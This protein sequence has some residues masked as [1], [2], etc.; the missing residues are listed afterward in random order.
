VKVTINIDGAEQADRDSLNLVFLAFKAQGLVSIKKLGA[1]LQEWS[2]TC[3]GITH[4]LLVS[5]NY[6]NTINS[7]HT[8]NSEHNT[9]PET[10]SQEGSRLKSAPVPAGQ[11]AQE[12]IVNDTKPKYVTPPKPLELF[13]QRLVP[14][15]EVQDFINHWNER[16]WLPKIRATDRQCK[17]IRI[18]L[19]RPVFADM[20]KQGVAEV[21]KSKFLRGAVPGYNGHKFKMTIDWFLHPDNFDKIMEGK[22]RDE[23]PEIP[24]NKERHY[25]KENL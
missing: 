11:S 2:F 21:A 23:E 25:D 6:V 24:P 3:A 9:N 16:V 20:Y 19:S 1:S 8:T 14:R 18:A 7:N 13:A 10:H 4:T 5:I 12:T 17:E 15:H 22:Y